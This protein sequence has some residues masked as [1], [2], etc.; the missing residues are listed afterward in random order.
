LGVTP[1]TITRYE[2]DGAP[3]ASAQT[4]SAVL[5]FPEGF[6]TADEAPEVDPGLVSF[7]A[8]RKTTARL[9]NAAVAAGALGIEI[10]RWISRRFTL[11]APSLPTHPHEDPRL[12]ARLVRAEWALGTRPL[13][14]AVQLAESRGIRV[15]TLPLIA[16][17]V[18]AYSLWHGDTPFMFLSRR[19]TPE[20][21]RFEVS[22][23]MGHVA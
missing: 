12:A 15:Y 14:N 3:S 13:P 9:R 5:G 23:A 2:S 20:R 16:E 4:L 8:A 1:R 19:K 21:M 11:P 6:F 18:D 7:R 22:H 10:D 17:E